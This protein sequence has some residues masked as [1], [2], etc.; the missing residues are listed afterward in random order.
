LGDGRD[1][2]GGFTEKER[3]RYAEILAEAIELVESEGIDY[4]VGG[5]LAANTWG[6]PTSIGDIDIIVAPTDAERL[7]KAFEAD[8][9]ETD[10]AESWLYKAK[11]NDVTVDIIFEMEFS[12]YLDDDMASH[13]VLTELFDTRL[14]LISP[15]DYIVSQALSTKED[16]ATY[17]YNALSVIATTDLDWE[18]LSQRASRGPRRVLS[19]L[20]YAESNDLPIP[21]QVIRRLFESV[22]GS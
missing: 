15:E 18:Y 5:S 8:G 12:M 1:I 4:A 3:D 11:K 22:Y 9:Y 6:R 19:L 17:W 7:I 21:K 10:Q 20:I 13:T 14:S 16:T 2:L